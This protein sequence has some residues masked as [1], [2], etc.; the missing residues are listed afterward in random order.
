MKT[1]FGMMVVVGMILTGSVAGAVPPEGPDRRVDVVGEGDITVPLDM[2]TIVV[3]AEAEETTTSAAQKK[4]DKKLD[5]IRRALS[6]LQIKEA[7]V[8]TTRYE[9]APKIV[10]NPGRAPKKEGYTVSSHLQ[11][12]VRD[13]KS[14]GKVFDAVLSAGADTVSGSTFGVSD[15]STV[16]SDARKKAVDDARRKALELA[17]QAGAQLGDVISLV[18]D[19]QESL[20][21]QPVA[22]RAMKA[23]VMGGDAG[24][25]V[26]PGETE[27]HV[28]VRASFALK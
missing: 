21:P 20:P 18:E 2:A 10:Y 3:G 5:A 4:V 6:D 16:E 9:V 28:R 23:D 15:R 14:V 24:F 26:S 7:D 17:Q 12:K 11:V 22:F 27:I 8:R 1:R 13:I 19:P 25:P